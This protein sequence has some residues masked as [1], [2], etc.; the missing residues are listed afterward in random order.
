MTVYFRHVSQHPSDC[1]ALGQWVYDQRKLK[2]KGLLSDDKIEKLERVGFNWECH[3]KA[4]TP[5]LVPT[6]EL[7]R[8]VQMMEKHKKHAPRADWTAMLK[9]HLK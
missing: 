6:K 3:G 4:P 9:K 1:N 7:R 8:I 2:K 5:H